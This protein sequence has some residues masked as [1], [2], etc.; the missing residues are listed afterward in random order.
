MPK[1]RQFVLGTL[2]TLT[3]AGCAKPASWC[4]T[5]QWNEDGSWPEDCQ[6]TASDIEGPYYLAGSPEVED[7][8]V[9]GDDGDPLRVSG[10]VYEA[11]CGAGL[12]GA[13]VEVWHASP[14]GGYDDSDEMRY[15]AAIVTDESGAYSFRTLLPGRYLNGSTYRPRH[16]HVKVWVDGE[17]RLTTQLYFEGDEYLECDAFASTSLVMP[18]EDDDER[19]QIA[20]GIDLVLA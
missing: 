16:I 5:P 8:D 15:R 10:T 1:R 12:V 7:L 18:R 14:R 11:G 17:E 13:I 9:W 4:S 2:A 6:V 3:E 19:G 20:E